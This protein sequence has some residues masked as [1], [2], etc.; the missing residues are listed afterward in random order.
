MVLK[1]LSDLRNIVAG[2]PVRKL[3]LAAAQDEH[4]LGA[5]IRA[6]KDN[7]IEPILIGDK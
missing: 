4:S 7:L 5:V 6:W 1:S 2:G 3:V